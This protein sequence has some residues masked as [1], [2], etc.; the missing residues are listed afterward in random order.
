MRS[1]DCQKFVS[2]DKFIYCAFEKRSLLDSV[3][4]CIYPPIHP[5]IESKAIV[6][7]FLPTS[8]G[9]N[10][11]S[12]WDTKLGTCSYHLTETN[13][14]KDINWNHRKNQ[15]TTAWL[16]LFSVVYYCAGEQPV[17]GRRAT[18][19]Q[20]GGRGGKRG[21]WGLVA[22]VRG[23]LILFF[24]ATSISSHFNNALWH[25]YKKCKLTVFTQ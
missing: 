13:E 10:N 17:N 24:L 25:I 11:I 18:L 14:P 21:R 9:N 12:T 7:Q 22:G 5:P 15:T 8:D 20:M 16:H 19:G 2:D 4:V 3:H 6:S 1:K 23:R